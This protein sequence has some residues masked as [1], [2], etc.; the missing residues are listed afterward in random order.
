MVSSR[1][2]WRRRAADYCKGEVWREVREGD[3][4]G[5]RSEGRAVAVGW[6]R[7]VGPHLGVDKD[8]VQ[9]KDYCE[10]KMQISSF[11]FP[12]KLLTTTK[13]SLLTLCLLSGS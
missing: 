7:G 12:L 5:G 3:E 2:K 10:S 1:M 4:R 9:S 8:E 11:V 6:W 13:T